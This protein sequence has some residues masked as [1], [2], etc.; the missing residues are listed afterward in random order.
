MEVLWDE[1]KDGWIDR[2]PGRKGGHSVRWRGAERKK[3]EAR[4]GGKGKQETETGRRKES[5]R[6]GGQAGPVKGSFVPARLKIL[7]IGSGRPAA[8][9]ALRVC[10]CV[11]QWIRSRYSLV[12]I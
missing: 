7:L 11:S 12:K 3:N 4:E 2:P 5:G 8:S 9:S 6:R 1:W 10:V